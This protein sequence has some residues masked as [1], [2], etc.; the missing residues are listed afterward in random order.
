[1]V[2]YDLD[3]FASM[4][5]YDHK[6]DQQFFDVLLSNILDLTIVKPIIESCCGYDLITKEDLTEMERNLKVVGALVDL[7]TLATG[8]YGF[9]TAA[10]GMG[11]KQAT[12]CFAKLALVELASDMSATAV[13]TIGNYYDWPAGL[14]L[15][16][17]LGTG[18]T[19]GQIGNELVL[20]RNGIEIFRKE[21]IEGGS[22]NKE[23]EAT[24]DVVNNL[25]QINIHGNINSELDEVDLV[26]KI[27]YEDKSASLLYL[28]NPDFPQTEAQWAYKH[29]YKK[30]S[31]RI[32]ALQQTDFTLSG[33][34]SLPDVELLKGIKE[35]V[36]GIDA[37]TPEL[38]AAVQKELDNLKE[39]FPD[40]NFSAIFGGKK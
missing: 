31:N 22:G 26:N 4:G 37:D 33:S 25:K 10:K 32:I 9:S 11:W 21:V 2:P 8:L 1:M 24:T 17:S 36:F 18:I 39:A 34:G 38:R 14:T 6:E 30:G 28:D 27:I 3:Q 19:V 23:I 5:E 20:K 40:Y 13:A 29:I 16:L 35:Y 12:A 15:L 7:V